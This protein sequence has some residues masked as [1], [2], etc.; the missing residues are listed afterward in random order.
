MS[1]LDKLSAIEIKPDTRISEADREFCQKHQ[2]AYLEARD[3]LISIKKQWQTIYDAQMAVM[4]TI[5]DSEY[6]RDRYGKGKAQ[7]LYEG[8]GCRPRR[9]L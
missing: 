9:D 3:A 4:E 8:T 6:T 1:L 5:A 2:K 7:P